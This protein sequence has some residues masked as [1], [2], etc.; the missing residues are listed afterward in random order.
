MT[1]LIVKILSLTGKTS[2]L[3]FSPA[4]F[5]LL[6][7]NIFHWFSCSNCKYCCCFCCLFCFGWVFFV[8]FCFCFFGSFCF[9]RCPKAYG[10]P[11]PG[12]RLEAQLWPKPQLWQHRLLNPLCQAG[13]RTCI[14]VL[15][16]CH[17]SCCTTAGTPMSTLF[18]KNKPLI[19]YAQ[20]SLQNYKLPLQLSTY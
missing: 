18:L 8:L 12:S 13:H 16:R 15:L 6:G 1:W 4:S 2:S 9:F 14:L 5:R 10:F 3:P 7:G 20:I 19:I 17:P 11:R